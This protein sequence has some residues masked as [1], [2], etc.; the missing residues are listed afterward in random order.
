[1]MKGTQ[2]PAGAHEGHSKTVDIQGADGA[3]EWAQLDGASLAMMQKM[4][5]VFYET[6]TESLHQV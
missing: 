1:M 2:L 3:M 6:L 5:V 4:L